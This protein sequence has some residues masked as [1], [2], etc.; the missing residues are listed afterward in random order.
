MAHRGLVSRV[1]NAV[2]EAKRQRESYE[3]LIHRAGSADLRVAYLATY[4]AT[5]RLGELL[6]LEYGYRFGPH[7]HSCLKMLVSSLEPLV[8]IEGLVATRHRAKKDD[9][10]PG[11]DEVDA[12]TGLRVRLHSRVEPDGG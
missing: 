3:R 2:R 12:L 7:P 4:D 8:D 11:V 10:V 9:H 5:M 1:D 6:L